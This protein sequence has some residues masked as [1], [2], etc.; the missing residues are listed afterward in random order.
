[1]NLESRVLEALNKLAPAARHHYTGG[2]KTY[3]TFFIVSESPE[4]FADDDEYS[5][6]IYLQVDVWSDKNNDAL[7]RAV[8]KSMKEIGAVF[9]NS[10]DLYE[11]TTE[12]YHKVLEFYFMEV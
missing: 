12:T 4:S 7:A 8:R 10:A 1:V 3:I 5:S 2:A 11:R 6:G 9:R